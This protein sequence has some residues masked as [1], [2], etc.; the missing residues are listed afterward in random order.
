MKTKTQ[1]AIQHFNEHRYKKSFSIFAKFKIN[2]T[3]NEQRSIQIAN[4][5]IADESKQ[6][7]Y[8]AI[9]VDWKSEIKNAKQ[10]IRLKFIK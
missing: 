6:C 3:K 8:S 1:I 4:E 10:I 7:F 5:T 2:L 9:G